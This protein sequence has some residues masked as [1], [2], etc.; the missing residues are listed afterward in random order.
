MAPSALAPSALP[1]SPMLVH[2][3]FGLS[4]APPER[5][6]HFSHFAAVRSAHLHLQPARL[7]MHHHHVPTGPWWEEAK[8]LLELRRVELPRSIFGRTLS[9]AAH[10]A[11]VLRLQ[12]LIELGG[13]YIDLDVVV[14]RPMHHLLRGRKS[15]V[16]GR[17]GH[18]NHGG[19]HG[20][21]NAV[22]LARPNASFARRWLNEYRDFG[23]T[24]A[25]TDP[26]SEHSVQRPVALAARHPEEVRILPYNAFF[27]PDWDEAELQQLL[28]LR[29]DP[30]AHLARAAAVARAPG[31]ATGGELDTDKE[32]GE[33]EEPTQPSTAY[34]VHLWSSSGGRFVLDQWSP[35]YLL[36][37]PSSLNCIMRTSL[38]PM[39][40]APAPLPANVERGCSYAD[41]PAARAGGGAGGSGALVAHWPLRRPPSSS[42]A[43]LLVD[44]SGHCHHGWVYS[45]CS[46]AAAAQLAPRP[47][48]PPWK[49]LSRDDFQAREHSHVSALPPALDAAAAASSAEDAGCWAEPLRSGEGVEAV[50][51]VP[52]LSASSDLQAFAPLPPRSLASG[53]WTVSWWGSVHSRRDRCGGRAVFWALHFAG[54]GSLI[55]SAENLRSRHLVPVVRWRGRPRRGLY[56]LLAR[57]GGYGDLELAAHGASV[58]SNG[59][60]HYTLVA[61]DHHL[62]MYI[63]AELWAETEWRWPRGS[64]ID[65]VVE[66][67]WVGGEP[68]VSIS[69][70]APHA[71]AGPGNAAHAVG[72]AELALLHGA[73]APDALPRIIRQPSGRGGALTSVRVRAETTWMVAAVRWVASC[74]SVGDESISSSGGAD[75]AVMECAAC[76]GV[77]EGSSDSLLQLP[78]WTTRRRSGTDRSS[79]V[80]VAD[81][82]ND[83]GGPPRDADAMDRSLR[84]ATAT[85][86][87]LLFATVVVLLVLSARALRRRRRQALAGKGPV[88]PRPATIPGETPFKQR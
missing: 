67:M 74:S 2:F 27:W 84:A 58:C 79:V 3:V 4:D 17:E 42:S 39:P 19:L 62:R 77:A 56:P 9:A 70:R 52:T 22:L 55:A 10:R 69:H 83:K 11:D 35:D 78:S 86:L 36:S 34:A 87:Y 46:A 25:G 80:D 50:G 72:V 76:D 6:F 37:V 47:R 88:H 54:G 23:T 24:T 63:D 18:R 14:L 66:G 31:G 81:A 59:W 51:N 41:H 30:L 68:V 65:G 48:Q 64:E 44:V 28:L 32:W 73:V 7:L 21:C 45:H 82:D 15:F 85:Q 20:L 38:A 57:L 26:W 8:K 16:I 5:E 1:P 43:R 13:L 75:G 49:P 29:S 40:H 60:H 71:H 61:S 33:D 53:E 12:L